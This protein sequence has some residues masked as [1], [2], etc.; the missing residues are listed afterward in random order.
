MMGVKEWLVLLWLCLIFN[1]R[2]GMYFYASRGKFWE[3]HLDQQSLVG[4][5]WNQEIYPPF[6]IGLRLLLLIQ[7]SV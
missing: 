1:G 5:A 6:T 4:E 2:V 7:L 3:G